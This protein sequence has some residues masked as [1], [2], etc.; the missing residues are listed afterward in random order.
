MWPTTSSGC[1]RRRKL[2]TS[3]TRHRRPG[4]EGTLHEIYLEPF[5]RALVRSGVA[6]LL[7]SYNRLKGRYTCQYPDLL[8]IPRTH[9][10]WAGFTVPD[11]LFAVRD[12]RAALEVG[13]DLPALLKASQV[14][15][16][17]PGE[18]SPV[19]MDIPIDDLAI[20]DDDSRSLVVPG[21]TKSNLASRRWTS[22]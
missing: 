18:V 21:I 19:G 5:R 6:G 20:Y 10:R 15:R 3:V 2:H 12:P 14:V 8:D 4:V 1:A 7:G 9:W 11:F 16:L 17:A 22:D 13:L